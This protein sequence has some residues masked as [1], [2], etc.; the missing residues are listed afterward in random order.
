[1]LQE[2]NGVEKAIRGKLDLP[3]LSTVTVTPRRARSYVSDPLS[4]GERRPG[5]G[6]HRD[7]G[8][9]VHCVRVE[10]S[11]DGLLHSISLLQHVGKSRRAPASGSLIFRSD[12]KLVAFVRHLYHPRK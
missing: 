2:A 6:Q 10:L 5:C 8:A 12:C 4:N 11:A 3:S 9:K 1:M 7:D